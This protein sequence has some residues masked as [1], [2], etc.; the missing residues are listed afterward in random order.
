MDFIIGFIIYI[1]EVLFGAFWIRE[2]VYDFKRQ[3]YF[4][5]GLDVMTV[6]YCMCM[7]AKLCFNV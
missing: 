4:I 2:A 7:L 1:V 6:A 5:F 3:R